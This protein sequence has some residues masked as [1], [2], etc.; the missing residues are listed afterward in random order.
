MGSVDIVIGH[1][2][3]AAAIPGAL[4]GFRGLGAARGVG[5]VVLLSAPNNAAL[6]TR[7]FADRVGLAKRGYETLVSA[8][9]RR[10]G[11]PGDI[12][13]VGAQLGNLSCKSLLV[14]DEQD[15]VV[16][17]EELARLRA[18]SAGHTSVVHTTRD[19]KHPGALSDRDTIRVVV[20][21]VE[22]VL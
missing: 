14:Y 8:F 13:T 18:D 11:G 6:Y 2:M 20:D 9:D 22:A 15:D 16:P 21:F 7:V 5:A 10:F 4:T 1:S 19:L 17:I 3:G 12:P